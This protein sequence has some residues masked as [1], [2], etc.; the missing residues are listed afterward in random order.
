MRTTSFPK[1]AV[2]NSYALALLVSVPVLTAACSDQNELDSRRTSAES[3]EAPS[4]TGA[5]TDTMQGHISITLRPS[6]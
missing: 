1:S 6:R 3:P 5:P 4:A 2:L